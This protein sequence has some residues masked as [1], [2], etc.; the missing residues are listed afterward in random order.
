MYHLKSKLI[1]DAK[2]SIIEG[3]VKVKGVVVVVVIIMYLYLV[4]QSWGVG[5][6]WSHL[7]K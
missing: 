5:D 2:Y 6:V 3:L 1:C 4:V 7:E